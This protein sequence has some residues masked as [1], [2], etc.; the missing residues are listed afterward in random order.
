MIHQKRPIKKQ[1]FIPSFLLFLTLNSCG[2][3]NQFWGES[4]PSRKSVDMNGDS[5]PPFSKIFEGNE[6]ESK[7]TLQAWKKSL[8]GTFDQIEGQK[9]NYLSTSE[10]KALIQAGFLRLD[11]DP[12]LNLRKALSALELLGFNEGISLQNVES[13]FQWLETHHEQAQA[14]YAQFISA[15]PRDS[16][17]NSKNLLL[18]IQF[19]GSFIAQGGDESIS[20]SHLNELAQ[21]WL[22]EKSIYLKAGFEAGMD[23]AIHF[24]ASLCGDR[25][26]TELW[27]GKKIGTCLHD[28]GAHF[29][30]TAPVFDFL[31]G[32]INPIQE[33]EKLKA[34]NQ[35]LVPT[36]E[37]WLKDHHHPAFPTVKVS[38][39][40]DKL[41]LAP[42]YYFFKLTEWLPKLNANSSPASL[43][44]TLFLDIALLA[45]HWIDTVVSATHDNTCKQSHWKDCE[46]SEENEMVN[47]IFAE[48]Y[49]LP[50]RKRDLALLNRIAL[51]D[52]ASQL[53]LAALDTEKVGYL[54]NETK[55]LILLAT[56]MIDSHA[57][58]FNVVQRI[59]GNPIGD[60]NI[61]DDLKNFDQSGLGTLMA[62]AS[63][64][65]PKREISN[66]GIFSDSIDRLGITSLLYTYQ[67]M[68]DLRD[69]YLTNDDLPL[70]S[71]INAPYIRRRKMMEALPRIL[72]EHFPEIYNACLAWG[73]ERTCG[74]VYSEVLVTPDTGKDVLEPYQLDLFSLSS[75]LLESMMYRCDANHDGALST[76]LFKGTDEK[77]CMIDAAETLVTRLMYAKI[78]AKNPKIE[79]MMG[80]VHQIAIIRWAG[81]VAL[82][83]GTMKGI[84]FS[85]LPPISIFSGNASL[86]SVL[87]LAA[88]LMSSDKVNAI[89]NGTSTPHPTPGDEVIF[90][91]TL[92]D[93]YLP[94]D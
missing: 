19:F 65:I 77:T 45:E 78:L 67:L 28:L 80:L 64:I 62:L 41:S 21:P 73:F 94:R 12:N 31:F 76:Q 88:E 5:L 83:K 13:L 81:K 24:F 58:T 30:N 63:D 36:L 35:V 10:I 53:L 59:I 89:E 22:P 71:G 90:F 23:F 85:V 92:T 72:H 29:K 37:S 44:P 1:I 7:N 38:N 47:S 26:E 3:K 55:D 68:G 87:S 32:A 60:T 33:N 51:D 49:G 2:L 86:G 42:P 61:E 93:H 39:F 66:R 11:P 75:L 25:V 70:V 17:L 82:S 27:N 16:S 4:A 20:A 34:A 46:Y 74:V 8:T 15:T 56:R 6:T 52:A 18:L 48:N 14:F 57:F 43:S 79:K 9:K 91:N 40:A 50:K 84:I 54:K 69:D